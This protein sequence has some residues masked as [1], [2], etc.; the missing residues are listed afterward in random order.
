ML[1][2]NFF[3]G[4]LQNNAVR[5]VFFIRTLRLPSDN[6]SQWESQDHLF[7]SHALLNHNGE[8][9]GKAVCLQ[10]LIQEVDPEVH[11]LLARQEH[12]WARNLKKKENNKQ[13]REN[14][15]S[16]V[17]L[18]GVLFLLSSYKHW[19]FPHHPIPSPV[20]PSANVLPSALLTLEIPIP[21]HVSTRCHNRALAGSSPRPSR[22]VVRKRKR[23]QGREASV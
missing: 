6:K 18:H 23:L 13:E 21:S 12:P 15:L 7:K 9:R 11:I 5:T 19:H 16:F 3:E 2:D 20:P 14:R 22:M 17:L 1:L 10:V 8:R 4:N